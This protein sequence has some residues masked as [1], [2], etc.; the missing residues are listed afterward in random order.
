MNRN[1][2]LF[3]L[4]LMKV[5]LISQDLVNKKTKFFGGDSITMIDYM[6]WPWFDRLEMFELK[7]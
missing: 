6:M 1:K 4:T 3:Y 7:Q 5:M 2:L